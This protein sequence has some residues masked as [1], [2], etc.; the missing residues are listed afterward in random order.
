[1]D[2]IEH[3]PNPTDTLSRMARLLAP[4]GHLLV[5]TGSLDATAWKWAGGRFWYC[6][7][8]EHISFAS[9]QWARHVASLNDLDLTLFEP[10]RYDADGSGRPVWKMKLAFGRQW[11]R[12]RLAEGLAAVR[13]RPLEGRAAQRILGSQG[14]FEDH[15]L[16][17]FRRR[18]R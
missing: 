18:G 10:F 7:F 17:G 14:L 3:V 16:M 6:S 11:L 13:G 5:S 12:T 2:V 9:E 4:G 8:P 15:V 1:M